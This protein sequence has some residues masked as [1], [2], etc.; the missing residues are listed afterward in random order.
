M[1]IHHLFRPREWHPQQGHRAWQNP[2]TGQRRLPVSPK[3]A[4]P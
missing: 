1:L 4:K 2:L 3:D